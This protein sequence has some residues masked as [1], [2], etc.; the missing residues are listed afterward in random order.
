MRIALAQAVT[1]PGDIDRNIKSMAPLV[2][3]AR[4]QGAKLILFSESAITGY[5]KKLV[6]IANAVALDDTRLNAIADM[7]R[8]S[9]VV[10]VAGTYE[11]HVD[12]TYNTAIVFFPDGRRLV[13]RKN[14]I[15]QWE[16][17]NT[18]VLSAPR[19][20]EIFEV[21]GMRF[22][23]LICADSG[24]KGIHEELAAQGVDCVLAPTAGMG[25]AK[26]AFKQAE[27][28]DRD[29]LAAYLK[30]AESVT[31][32]S[33][34]KMVELNIALACCNQ[35]G[36]DEKYAYFQPGHAAVIDRTGECTAMMP[37]RFVVEHQHPTVTVGTVSYRA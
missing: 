1:W 27:L 21:D 35:M 11:K 37:G 13:Q 3:Q 28:K 30:A 34:Q 19:R 2:E 15:I 22:A 29:R 33:P 7:A 8:S 26:Y 25:D 17:E 16:H 6:G 4:A 20:R 23:I 36:Y 5:D 24:L 32:I 12:G 10:V 18:P 14:Y 9:G 31:F